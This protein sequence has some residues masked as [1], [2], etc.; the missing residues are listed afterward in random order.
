MRRWFLALT[1]VLGFGCASQS[2]VSDSK[3]NWLR[4]CSSNSQCGTGLECTCGVCT[5]VCASANDCPASSGQRAVCSTT[6]NP[7]LPASCQPAK[8]TSA[9]QKICL[10]ACQDSIECGTGT[11][12]MCVG[13]VCVGTLGMDAGLPRD[14]GTDQS[15]QTRTPE[16]G[17][18][19]TPMPD[20]GDGGGGGG[21]S[22]SGCDQTPLDAGRPVPSTPI[23]LP[24]EP[25]SDGGAS[26]PCSSNV[27]C[28]AGLVCHVDATCQPAGTSDGMGVTTIANVGREDVIVAADTQYVYGIRYVKDNSSAGSIVRWPTG[29]GS[30][31][32]LA[33]TMTFQFQTSATVPFVPPGHPGLVPLVVDANSIYFAAT[34]SPMEL[35][36]SLFSMP[37][38]GSALPMRHGSAGTLLT[39]DEERLY[40]TN[41]GDS[42][43]LRV[44]KT[45]LDVA[46]AQEQILASDSDAPGSIVGLAVN[47]SAIFATEVPPH[48]QPLFNEYTIQRVDKLSGATTTL[49]TSDALT[50]SVGLTFADDSYFILGGASNVDAT[51]RLDLTTGQI[52]SL[53]PGRLAAMSGGDLFTTNGYATQADGLTVVHVARASFA[54]LLK[55]YTLEPYSFA[56]TP[57]TLFALVNIF[58]TRTNTH[59]SSLV[60]ITVPP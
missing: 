29:G 12:E 24:P 10:L 33:G 52:K 42:R 59:P 41:D 31:E 57:G 49:A 30:G 39:Q 28:P 13:G 44:Q 48:A 11:G 36:A 18:A 56:A 46:C 3:S 32:M 22:G 60:R 16:A 20:G 35:S 9:A 40:L 58:D 43:V 51:M 17:P 1:L 2:G 53:L 38:D 6:A 14:S 34:T 47:S 23:P 15:V 54:S 45:L 8:K 19:P 7:A 5:K 27:P 50:S 4:Q 55:G 37:K 21:A 25:D 26:Q